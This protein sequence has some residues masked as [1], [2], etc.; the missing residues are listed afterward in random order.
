MDDGEAT[1]LGTYSQHDDDD[2]D[3]DDDDAGATGI[4]FSAMYL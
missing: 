3:D 2:D 4:I 1:E